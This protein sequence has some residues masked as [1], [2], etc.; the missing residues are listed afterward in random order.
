VTEQNTRLVRRVI[1][2]IWNRGDLALADALFAPSY[3]NHGGLIP[4]LVYGPEAIKSGVTL[5]RTAFPTFHITVET[6]VAEGEM[7]ELH[8]SARRTPCAASAGDARDGPEGTLRGTTRSRLAG[9]QIAE[10]WTTWDRAAVLRG[11][12]GVPAE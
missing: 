6:L 3:V 1:E 5:Y 2:E 9:G 11:L 7:V 10:S 12:S 8:W 4:D